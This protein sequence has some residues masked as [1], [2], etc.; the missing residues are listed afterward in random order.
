MPL[1][2]QVALLETPRPGVNN[3]LSLSHQG[4]TLSNISPSVHFTS[5]Q[6]QAAI[7]PNAAS[8]THAPAPPLPMP[9][10][11]VS[12]TSHFNP[13]TP[14]LAPSGPDRNISQSNTHVRRLEPFI[15]PLTQQQPPPNKPLP[16]LPSISS[17][18]ANATTNTSARRVYKT[19]PDLSSIAGNDA[20][21]KMERPNAFA[22]PTRQRLLSAES[23][24]RR[25]SE[26]DSDVD[27]A[28]ENKS[29]K[30]MR[31][32]LRT[33]VSK[34]FGEEPTPR[35]ASTNKAA[36]PLLTY[37]P[38]SLSSHES[39]GISLSN[40]FDD[41]YNANRASAAVSEKSGQPSV[42]T[43]AMSAHSAPPHAGPDNLLA[44][45][46]HDSASLSFSSQRPSSSGLSEASYLALQ[47]IEGASHPTK[48]RT[49]GVELS[50]ANLQDPFCT[51]VQA[52]HPAD[53]AGKAQ[54]SQLFSRDLQPAHQEKISTEPALSRNEV[55]SSLAARLGLNDAA[56]RDAIV[57]AFTTIAPPPLIDHPSNRN[58]FA[59]QERTD[60]TSY[61]SNDNAACT[62]QLPRGTLAR[63]AARP[64]DLGLSI[65]PLAVR[66]RRP[67][68]VGLSAHDVARPTSAAV[69]PLAGFV[70]RT[71]A[72]VPDIT[73][74]RDSAVDLDPDPAFD[75]TVDLV[76]HRYSVKESE[77]HRVGLV[78]YVDNHF[79]HVTSYFNAKFSRGRDTNKYNQFRERFP[80]FALDPSIR[81]KIMT[82][83]LEDYL[84]GKPILLNRKREASPAWPD[85]T[86][87]GLWDVLGP[88]QNYLTADP[89]LRADVMS[90]FLMT[91]PFHVIFSPFVQGE[92][93]PLPTKWLFKYLWF[94]QDVR[95]E[96][97]MTKLGFGASWE[98]SAMSTR[99]W[100]MGNLVHVFVEEMLKRDGQRNPLRQ[101]T[102]HCRRYF[103]YRQ[104][105]NPFHGDKDVY[106][107]PLLHGEEDIKSSSLVDGRPWNFGRKSTSLPPSANNPFSGHRRHHSYGPDRVPYV[108]ESHMSIANPFAR[109]TGRVW[110]V[111][112]CGLSE[113]WVK[114]NHIK[115]WPQAEFEAIKDPGIHLD[116]YLP[117]RHTY[118]PRGHAIYLD[119]G[120]RSGVHRYPPL[121]DSEPMV[122]TPYDQQN[123]C[124]VEV[125]SG[126]ILTVFENGVE[127]IARVKNPPMP[128]SDLAQAGGSY[129]PLQ[130]MRTVS[131]SRIPGPI[132]GM[133][134]PSMRALRRGTPQKA[135]QLLGLTSN[136][137]TST[138]TPTPKDITTGRDSDEDDAVTPTR[139]GSGV[140][141]YRPSTR[142]IEAVDD[143][144]S[145][146]L[147]QHNKSSSTKASSSRPRALTSKMS[148]LSLKSADRRKSA[149]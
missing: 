6:S 8:S 43:S 103:G 2:D 87:A 145:Q 65:P 24:T 46:S 9:S 90:A 120:I 27:N 4:L 52:S 44:H 117:S 133:P 78:P 66:R 60:S 91:Q 99:L 113:D 14:R 98:A 116:R 33:K 16:S 7:T 59:V 88:L 137:N 34:L 47:D 48:P 29:N 82:K 85:G 31:H 20:A 105:A 86:F 28:M 56:S 5:Q 11:T 135:M 123:D 83:L 3:H 94:M 142:L 144:L 42:A 74:G 15:G 126:N 140:A 111:R 68:L 73:K 51:S 22:T 109:L 58:D 93:S 102:I 39:E 114:E 148:F 132:G 72:T 128:R 76:W 110:I 106:K 139:P 84:P 118:A 107:H 62:I 40:I 131:P 81:F 71:L 35:A 32:G 17:A 41:V 146:L 134:S 26:T 12:D 143:Q 30:V 119:Y 55:A 95:V 121:P 122:C 92:T 127:V 112:M 70:K 104:G 77:T 21:S 19:S 136:S 115:F 124:F 129:I 23:K 101:L 13:P 49:A 125:G 130:G 80:Y 97:D 108:H 53:I 96:L 38:I 18:N 45:D 1:A 54:I 141:S 138:A 79:Y 89:R 63:L 149:E 69:E 57:N 147:D 36:A 67:T 64:R 10:D 25:N 100:T 75:R 61:D 37:R 50:T